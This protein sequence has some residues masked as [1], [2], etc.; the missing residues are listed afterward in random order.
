MPQQIVNVPVKFLSPPLMPRQPLLQTVERTAD[1][2]VEA[3]RKPERAK[4]AN[5]K[6]CRAGQT[7]PQLI[8]A[9]YHWRFIVTRFITQSGSSTLINGAMNRATTNRRCRE[10]AFRLLG[11]EESLRYFFFATHRIACATSF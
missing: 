1:I 2:D 7:Q 6:P 8:N 3:R 9:R 5:L 10:T 11:P 4:F